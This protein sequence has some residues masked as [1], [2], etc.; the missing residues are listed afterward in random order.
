[1]TTAK[2]PNILEGSLKIGDV[3]LTK[4][5]QVC[6][7][8]YIG[9]IPEKKS[10]KIWYG[11]LIRMTEG[12]LGDCDGKVGNK[13]YFTCQPDGGLFVLLYMIERKITPNELLDK[14]ILILYCFV[15]I[16]I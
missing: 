16:Y 4:N 15:Y 6:V 5:K 11:L 14:G 2:V 3:V 8:K 12:P 9:K 1:M 10:N 13:I 7:V